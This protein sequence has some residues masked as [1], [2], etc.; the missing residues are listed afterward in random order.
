[1]VPVFDSNY[2]ERVPK[3]DTDNESTDD[4]E[5]MSDSASPP[6]QTS[7]KQH[8][9]PQALFLNFSSDLSPQKVNRKPKKS[10]RQAAYRVNGVN[11]LNR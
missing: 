10:K 9:R 6:P 11:I 3:R 7:N 1:M 5:E 8:P 4:D 2:I